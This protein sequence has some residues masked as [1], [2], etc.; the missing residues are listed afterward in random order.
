MTKCNFTECKNKLYGAITII[1]KCNYCSKN[2]CSTHR[3]YEQHNC[4][5]MDFN[6]KIKREIL[7]KRLIDSKSICKKNNKID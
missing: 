5:G 3:L 1:G 4:S 6:N 7:S 2:Y